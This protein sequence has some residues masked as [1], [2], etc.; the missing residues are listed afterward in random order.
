MKRS[1]T[2]KNIILQSV[3]QAAVM[4]IPFV[5]AP[6]IS[7]VL[8][9]EQVGIY[10]YTYSIVN[11]FMMFAMLGIDY[12]GNRTIAE[13]RD[14]Q[15]KTNR[16]FSE[17]FLCHMIPSLMA[18]IIYLVYCF[19]MKGIYRTIAF[20]QV[21][22]IIG[23][24]LNINWLFAGLA[25]FKIT[26]YRNIFIKLL[27]VIL[28]FSFVKSQNDLISYIV[29]MAVGTLLSQSAVWIVFRKYVKFVKVNIRDVVKHL[30]PM[31]L[32]FVAVVA[33]NIYRMIDKT[34][35]GYMG[36]MESL[37]CYEYADKIIRLPLSVIIAIGAV[38]LSKTANM[39]A[40]DGEKKVIR[41][42]RSTLKYITLLASLI[43]FGIL[44]FG[45]DFSVLFLGRNYEET[46]LLLSILAISFLFMTWNSVL[47]TQYFMPNA[48]DKFYV[49]SVWIGAI[50]N[51]ILNIILIGKYSS[52][53][54]AIATD[55]SYFCVTMTQL[56]FARK[57]INLI[58][59]IKENVVP[60]L[61]GAIASIPLLFIARIFP[62]NWISF[63]IQ[64]C[65]YVF[66]FGII[67]IGYWSIIKDPIM[68]QIKKMIFKRK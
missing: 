30:K 41:L 38:M 50:V 17:V 65:I 64:G 7:R 51:I 31:I 34:M 28:I 26:V 39:L 40:V 10:S 9:A 52:K 42:L 20:I 57:V 12:Y 46:G 8:G 63:I 33:T 48:L 19:Q 62:Q 15:E 5:T 2:K 56:F 45:T 13:V 44:L 11:Y 32:L 14:N 61:C 21:V 55:I 18:V 43:I 27:T 25:E 35:L 68:V 24:L 53:G 66:I 29:I 16:V 60:F 59:V 3:Y 23:E 6:Y 47:R 67:T 4:I 58:E 22:Y 54:A 1:S 37:G 36:H 49:I